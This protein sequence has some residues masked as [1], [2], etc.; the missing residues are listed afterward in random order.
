MNQNKAKRHIDRASELL[1]NDQ[2]FGLWPFENRKPLH[3]IKPE[4]LRR[5]LPA[6]LKCAQKWFEVTGGMSINMANFNR[7]VWKLDDSD[8]KAKRCLNS[9]FKKNNI[10]SINKLLDSHMTKNPS[11]MGIDSSIVFASLVKEARRVG[12]TI[13][14]EQVELSKKANMWMNIRSPRT[15]NTKDNSKTSNKDENQ[16]ST[17]STQST[18]SMA[19]LASRGSRSPSPQRARSST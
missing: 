1:A 7:S 5:I 16:K 10:E 2:S 12:I 8:G 18:S 13:S 17:S 15:N 11:H 14:E 4:V 3:K 9:I 6:A 19:L